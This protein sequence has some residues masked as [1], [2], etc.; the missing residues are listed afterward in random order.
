MEVWDEVGVVW[1][2]SFWEGGEDIIGGACGGLWED[3]RRS[4]I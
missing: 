3:Y 2:G 4:L 1:G